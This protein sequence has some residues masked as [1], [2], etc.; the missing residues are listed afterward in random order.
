[1]SGSRNLSEVT[2]EE[3]HR[4]LDSFDVVFSDCDGEY[5]DLSLEAI[6]LRNVTFTCWMYGGYSV[7]AGRSMRKNCIDL[8]CIGKGYV[9]CR[10]FVY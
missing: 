4:F 2:V 1:M 3:L 8:K 10:G 6:D 5:S 7:N 9:G